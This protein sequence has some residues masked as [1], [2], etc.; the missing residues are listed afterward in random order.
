MIRNFKIEDEIQV[1]NLL[2]EFNYQLEKKS[3]DNDFLNILVYEDGF[4]KGALVYQYLI[5]RIEI[6]YVKVDERYRKNGIASKLLAAMIEK[7]NI[8]KNITLEVRK[9]NLPAINFYKKNGFTEVCIRKNYYKDEDAILM[10]K[11]LR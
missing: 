4:I 7:H 9:G 8:I 11:E 6:E 5:D 10:I 1:N 3:F 2:K